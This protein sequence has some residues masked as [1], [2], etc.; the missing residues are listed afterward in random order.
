MGEPISKDSLFISGAADQENLIYVITKDRKLPVGKIDESTFVDCKKGHI[1]V[2]G[3]RNWNAVGICIARKPEEQMV[4]VSEDGHVFTFKSGVAFDESIFPQPVGL[5]GLGVVNGFPVAFGMGRQ[6]YKRINENTWVPMHAPIPEIRENVGFLSI[7]G[8]NDNEMYVVG[9]NGEMWEWNGQVW[10]NRKTPF[11]LMLTDVCCGDDGQVYVCGQSGTLLKGRHNEW[12]SV[13]LEN[14]AD[15]YWGLSW[16]KDKLF[17]A[18]LNE[19]FTL[20]NDQLIP[21]N[22]GLHRPESFG[23]LTQSDG[24]LWSI[25]TSDLWN[26]DGHKW[27]KIDY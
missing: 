13:L 27:Q 23:K 25:G 24:I 4:V 7:S 1:G 8:F 22:F 6:V 20:E 9:F 3:N 15:D 19:L 21:V 10:K 11:N 14:N 26:F 12:E 17:I 16:F 5:R 2:I 18:T